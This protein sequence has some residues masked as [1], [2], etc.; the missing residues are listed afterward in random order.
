MSLFNIKGE[1]VQFIPAKV[2]SVYYK[3][4]KPE[5]TF[6]V[7]ALILD[8]YNSNREVNARPLFV[9]VK[10]PPLEGET[11]L[12]M[13]TISSYASGIASDEDM[14]YLGIINLQ[15]NVH[16][17]SL[18]NVNE[19]T[20]QTTGGGD[21]TSYQTVGAGS[22]KSNT[23]AKVDSKFPESKLVKSLQPYVGDVLIEGRFGTGIRFTSTLKNADVYT[24][25]ANWTKANGAEGDPMVIIRA[26]KPTQN[27]NKSNDF[28]TEDFNKDD[29]FI[30]LQTSQGINFKPGSDTNDS[31]KNQGLDSWDR[32]N[33]FSGKQILVSSG[34]IVF[35][36]TQN[37]IIAFAKKGFAIS[38]AGSVSIDAN[39]NIEMSSN[40]IL[41][42]K[43][44]DEPLVLG[45]KLK[46]W[47][48][49]LIEA[50]GAITVTTSM[51]PSGPIQGSPQW[52]RVEVLKAQFQTNLSQVAY[53]K[54]TK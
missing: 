1:S 42:G 38:S 47:I 18:P 30:T 29:S 27:T 8:G 22:P 28:I 45:N 35:N 16:H 26:S 3:D 50:I 20:V 51:G 11:V 39:Q 7:K 34:R 14:Y 21:S 37:E 53:T 48:G 10:Q 46:D 2:A 13:S 54:Q 49:Q 31:I 24:K 5:S 25:T 23:Q 40:K 36:S 6:Y 15:G 19:I 12:L 41:I 17:N 4:D 33:K 43:N 32:G 44:A 52:A 9:N